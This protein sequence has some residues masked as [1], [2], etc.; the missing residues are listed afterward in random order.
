MRVGT[1]LIRFSQCL[2]LSVGWFVV[3]SWGLPVEPSLTSKRDYPFRCVPTELM[4]SQEPPCVSISY[5]EGK[6]LLI[7]CKY[8]PGALALFTY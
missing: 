6:N 8:E 5:K 3:L 7:V 1:L 2:L 4:K